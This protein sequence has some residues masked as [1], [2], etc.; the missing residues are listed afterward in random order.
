[1]FSGNEKGYNV[2][3]QADF[4]ACLY[5]GVCEEHVN[6]VA[7]DRDHADDG[8][9]TKSESTAATRYGSVCHVNLVFSI[10]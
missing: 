6:K 7:D 1:V 10:E 2:T 5:E 8:R 3:R 9:P 4:Q